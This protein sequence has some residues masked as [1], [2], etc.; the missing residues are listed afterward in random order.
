MGGKRGA[1]DGN[2]I[3]VSRIYEHMSDLHWLLLKNL[4]V[5]TIRV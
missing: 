2:R 5:L 3:Y 1:I 4:R